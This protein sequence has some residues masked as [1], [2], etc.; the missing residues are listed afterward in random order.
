MWS[1]FAEP[2]QLHQALALSIGYQVRG[3]SVQ[4]Q[5]GQFSSNLRI[6]QTVRGVAMPRRAILRM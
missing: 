4:N 1:N 6:P 2:A 3:E 5:S